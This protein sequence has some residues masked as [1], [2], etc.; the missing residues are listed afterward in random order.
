VR[1]TRVLIVE[2]NRLF[3]ETLEL[4][5]DLREEIEVVGSVDGGAE[6]VELCRALSPEV[7]LMDYRMPGLD[8]ARATAAVLRASPGSRVI[9]LTASVSPQERELVLAAGAESCLMKDEGLDR[10]VEAILGFAGGSGVA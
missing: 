8:G 7:V 1:R 5:L 9:C 3:R 10:I 4:L 6:A 2:D